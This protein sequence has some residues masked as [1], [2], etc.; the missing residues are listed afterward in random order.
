MLRSRYL[1][2][3]SPIDSTDHCKGTLRYWYRR[4]RGYRTDIFSGLIFTTTQVSFITA[5]ITF[6]FA[7]LKLLRKSLFTRVGGFWST[8]KEIIRLGSEEMYLRSS[9]MLH[10]RQQQAQFSH[11]GPLTQ[12]FNFPCLNRPGHVKWMYR[13]RIRTK[14]VEK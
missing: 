1:G 14:S 11:P 6:I 3:L 13:L 2:L 8:P 12:N 10:F 9:H 7:Q 4:G 5:K